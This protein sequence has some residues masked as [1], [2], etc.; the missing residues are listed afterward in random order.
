MSMA[1][2]SAAMGP[3]RCGIVD[4]R[5]L[6]GYQEIPDSLTAVR[7][8]TWPGAPSFPRSVRKGWDSADCY[9]IFTAEDAES[10][11]EEECLNSNSSFAAFAVKFFG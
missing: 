7:T 2:I 11:E 9:Q 3:F 1:S 4:Q 6:L 10:A 5:T 8:G